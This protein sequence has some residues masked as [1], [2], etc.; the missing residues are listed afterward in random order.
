MQFKNSHQ[1]YG[2]VAQMFHWTVVVLIVIQFVL[3]N[4]AEDA[5]SELH[6]AKLLTMHKSVGMTVFML[7]IARLGWRLMN[8]VPDRVPN[9]I[10]WQVRLA[11]LVHWLLYALILATPLVGWLMSSAK[12]YT[13][14]WFGLFAFPNL[15]SPDEDR[16]QWFRTL[17]FALAYSIASIA[18]L[19]IVAALKH[20]FLDK[21][22]VLRRMLPLKLK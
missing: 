11:S 12:N 2:V 7:A 1:R 6:K 8:S 3:A 18:T 9:A 14:S 17:H 21:N 19:H 4:Q 16:F 20:H 15:V 10:P 5:G 22:D 13:V